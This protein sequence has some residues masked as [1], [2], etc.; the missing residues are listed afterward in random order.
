MLLIWSIQ[1]YNTYIQV[2]STACGFDKSQS[3]LV[4]KKMSF[5]LSPTP[6]PTHPTAGLTKQYTLGMDE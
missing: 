1:L 5:S 3:M 6:T 4:R 2:H